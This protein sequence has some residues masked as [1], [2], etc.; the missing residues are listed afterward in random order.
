MRL[1]VLVARCPAFGRTGLTIDGHSWRVFPCLPSRFSKEEKCKW[2][3]KLFAS[4]GAMSIAIAIAIW[5]QSKG[6]VVVEIRRR[7]SSHAT[8]ECIRARASSTA[9]HGESA[10]ASAR[11]DGSLIASRRGVVENAILIARSA[12]M[13]ETEREIKERVYDR[14]RDRRREQVSRGEEAKWVA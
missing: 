3:G 1:H 12:T 6:N 8:S 9:R 10:Q 2:C 14:D 11:L 7:R 13:T 4:E 5:M